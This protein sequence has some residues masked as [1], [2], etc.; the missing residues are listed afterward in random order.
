MPAD[1][2]ALVDVDSMYASVERVFRPDLRSVPVVVLSNNDGCAVARSREAKALGVAMGQPWFQ[3]KNNPR[4]RSVVALSSNF[5][6]YG[7]FSA[8]MLAVTER[9]TPFI[10]PYSIDEQFLRLPADR[11]GAIAWRLREQIGR[12]LGLPVS[13]GIASTKTLAKV[14]T[15]IAKD[16]RE[17]VH[18]LTAASPKSVWQVLDELPVG[19]VWG[20]GSRLTA[21]LAGHEVTS[22][23]Q[24]AR[25]DPGWVRRAFTVVVE[26]T[27]RELAGTPCL[28]VEQEPSPR[29]QLMHCRML[30]RPVAGQDEVAD[31]A[32]AFAQRVAARLRRYGRATNTVCVWLSTGGGFYAGPALSVQATQTLL[33]PT[34]AV[35]P[36]ARAAARLARVLWRPGHTFRRVGVMALDLVAEPGQQALWASPTGDD[37]VAAAVDAITARFGRGA[38][39]VGRAGFRERPVWAMRQERLS[40]AYTTRWDQL[41][42][43]H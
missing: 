36:L 38:I 27:V 30:G 11:A 39:G 12:W 5:A 17:G 16:R 6:L 34:N 25:L 8:R 42:V 28:P 7:D 33:A 32:S 10:H 29:R 31:V 35:V 37:A 26:R 4:Y 20:I 14:A 40:P 13:I 43:V 1:V 41:P 21:R 24:L 19:E 22:A 23:G 3:L 15:K 18:D 2:Y 9:H